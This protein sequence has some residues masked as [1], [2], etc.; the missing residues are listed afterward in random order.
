[1][2]AEQVP[3][4]SE[5]AR[6]VT[7]QQQK[8]HQAQPPGAPPLPKKPAKGKG[9]ANPAETGASTAVSDEAG[10]I[11]VPCPDVQIETGNGTVAIGT[12]EAETGTGDDENPEDVDMAEVLQLCN[13][14]AA[15]LER[16]AELE[17]EL[18]ELCDSNSSDSNSD[19]GDDISTDGSDDNYE[20]E[21][22]ESGSD[23]PRRPHRTFPV[24]IRGGRRRR[25]PHGHHA[26]AVAFDGPD[27]HPNKYTSKGRDPP[28]KLA[29]DPGLFVHW[30][31]HMETKF[32]D[33][34]PLFTQEI[35]KVDY[36]LTQIEE[37]L[38]SNMADWVQNCQRR[39]KKVTYSGF[40]KEVCDFLDL[41]SLSAQA[42]DS[43]NNIRMQ[44]GED[45]TALH[46]RLTTLGRQA[47]TPLGDC[48][49]QFCRA[50]PFGIQRA[51]NTFDDEDL[52][53]PRALLKKARRVECNNR[54]TNAAYPDNR[55]PGQSGGNRPNHGVNAPRRPPFNASCSAPGIRANANT[56]QNCAPSLQ[57]PASWVSDGWYLPER[58]PQPLQPHERRAFR[59][60]GRCYRCRSS[61]H[62]ADNPACPNKPKN[63]A[64]FWG[65]GPT[66][67][68][69]STSD[70][71]ANPAPAAAPAD[72]Q[73]N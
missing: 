39:Q 35:Y 54:R 72:T 20:D 28:K 31:F 27:E 33:D 4:D 46:G 7:R 5:D 29:N 38:W 24:E 52:P 34:A 56:F 9:G 63:R 73:E 2:T 59:E 57:Q 36:A 47:K 66:V 21:S 10:P 30:C 62:R 69:A 19:R 45:V 41:K 8:R 42:R 26:H 49:Y 64:V 1:M 25:S 68:A 65:T 50:L 18:H 67:A 12:K 43:L 13:D 32:R 37:P 17:A 48:L 55:Q 11:P 22:T 71:N 6:R 70:P 3:S 16:N 51:L 14:H 44:S 40:L 61:G 23:E 58:T 53:T 60:A 15:A